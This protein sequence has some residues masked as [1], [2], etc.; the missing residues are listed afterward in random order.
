MAVPAAV[1]G[2]VHDTRAKLQCTAGAPRCRAGARGARSHEESPPRARPATTIG[3]ASCRRPVLDHLVAEAQHAGLR[4][5]AAQLGI[6]GSGLYPQLQ[7]AGAASRPRPLNGHSGVL[8]RQRGIRPAPGSRT[9]GANSGAPSSRP[10]PTISPPSRTTTTCR[11]WS[12]PR[13][14]VY[15]RPSAPS[16]SGCALRTPRSSSGAWYYGGF[17][18]A[19]T[20]PN[21]TCSRRA[22]PQRLSTIP[23]LE[24]ACAR[25]TTR[26]AR[27]SHGHPVRCPSCRTGSRRS[28]ARRS[29]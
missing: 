5:G 14:R 23:E 28:R 27:C 4:R 12:L 13:R 10:I 20:I 29:T 11:C 22:P 18:T 15:M 1:V 16:N 9:S 6:A 7:Q 26:S 2:R 19:A 25:R 17:S 21:S 8:V 3:G 24:A